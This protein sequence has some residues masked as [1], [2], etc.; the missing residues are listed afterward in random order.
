MKRHVVTRHDHKHAPGIDRFQP[1]HRG[2]H[3][4]PR[5]IGDS[6]TG[7]K[8][9]STDHDG[10]LAKRR[11]AIA[12]KAPPDLRASTDLS[13]GQEHG[14]VRQQKVNAAERPPLKSSTA[15]WE[16]LTMSTG[17]YLDRI[18]EKRPHGGKIEGEKTTQPNTTAAA[19]AP[20][21]TR[22]TSA[23]FSKG[24]VK[25]RVENGSNYAS[26][27]YGGPSC[28]A[29]KDSVA[30]AE[31]IDIAP[32]GGDDV[33]DGLISGKNQSDKQQ[34][35]NPSMIR[36]VGGP[37]KEARVGSH[38][39]LAARTVDSGSPGGKIPDVTHAVNGVEAR[40]PG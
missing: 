37:G 14:V 11:A 23:E 40:K 9:P 16:G 19:A 38:P 34:H 10:I 32:R 21:T 3:N 8:A 35:G 6:L 15:N 4:G 5:V 29:V 1:S 13:P 33:L 26:M 12:A 25:P 31:G 18:D 28:V 7:S 2:E 39:G 30:L 27:G 36:T 24:W 20:R 22:P 17:N